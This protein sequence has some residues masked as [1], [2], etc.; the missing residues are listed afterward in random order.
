MTVTSPLVLTS[1]LEAFAVSTL[2]GFFADLFLYVVWLAL[3]VSIFFDRVRLL[4][5]VL[6][7]LLLVTIF[8]SSVVEDFAYFRFCV[9]DVEN[10]FRCLL[11]L[12]Y[13]Q[14]LM[15]SIFVRSILIA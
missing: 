11:P 5:I 7:H 3:V 13:V 2:P 1:H 10:A 12:V 6:R 9:L 15:F 4:R 8:S 14:R